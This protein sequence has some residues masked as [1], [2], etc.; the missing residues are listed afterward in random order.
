M[1]VQITTKCNFACSHCLFSCRPGAG[2]HM[3]MAVFEAVG[4]LCMD[5]ELGLFIGG[6]EPTL[7][8]RFWEIVGRT[9]Y[10]NADWADNSGVPPIALVTNGSRTDDA[11]ALAKLARCGYASVR[12]SRDQFHKRY[13]IDQRV[14]DAFSKSERGYSDRERLN[15]D[16]RDIGGDIT[17]V[18]PVGRAKRNG[19]TRGL[20][21]PDGWT[22][23]LWHAKGCDADGAMVTPDGTIWRCACRQ[24]KLGHVLTGVDCDIDMLRNSDTGCSARDGKLVRSSDGRLRTRE[25]NDEFEAEEKRY[26]LPESEVDLEKEPVEEEV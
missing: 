25:G 20:W 23:G 17:N 9:T 14:I 24:E 3:S 7:H 12:L 16:Y 19:W 11:L 2:T 8:P 22:R 18:L 13:P 5:H 4:R 21:R 10:F 1:Y 6:G 26:K 15:R